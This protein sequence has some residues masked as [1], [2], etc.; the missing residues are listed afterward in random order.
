MNVLEIGG[1][2]AAAGGVAL[3]AYIAAR[4]AVLTIVILVAVWASTIAIRD[5]VD[6]SVTV[7]IGGSDF[8]VFLADVLYSTV[9]VIGVARLLTLPPAADVSSR[10]AK[11]ALIT[12]VTLFALHLVR[13][14][15]EVGTQDAIDGSRDW[16]YFIA[17]LS[18][19]ATARSE[20]G[21]N[22]WKPFVLASLALS[23]IAAL[24]FLSEGLATASEFVSDDGQLLSR[25]AVIA[26][27]TLV[28]LEGAILA[29]AFRWPSRTSAFALAGLAGTVIVLLQ[30]R[31]VWIVAVV[32]GI[33][34]LAIWVRVQL[35][36]RRTAVVALAGIAL[37]VAIPLATL[38]LANTASV[39]Q[40]VEEA[41]GEQTTLTW[42]IDGWR[43]LLRRN[44]GA[45]DIIV[46]NASGS[47]WAR[48]YMRGP[49]G[50]LYPNEVSPHNEILDSYLRLG[51]FGVVG[52]CG[53]VGAILVRRSAVGAAV[54]LPE[55]SVVLLLLAIGV[56]SLTWS[57]DSMQGLIIGALA[58][59][60]VRGRAHGAGV[61]D[62][63]PPARTVSQTT[64]VSALLASHNRRESTLACLQSF[65]G[66]DIDEEISLNA[67][68]LDDGSRDGTAGAVTE[69]FGS[70]QVLSGSGDLFWAGGMAE[71]ERAAMGL[72]PDYLLWL[73]DDV[74]LD[75]DALSRLLTT[76]ALAEGGI[77]AGAL[78]DPAGRGIT[79]SGMRRVGRHPMRMEPVDPGDV[80]IEVD[81]FNGN[82]VLVPY[83]AARTIGPL[84]GALGHAAAD[85]DYGLRAKKAGLRNLLAPGTVGACALNTKSAPWLDGHMSFMERLRSWLGPKGFPPGSRARY[86][87]RHGGL[88]WPLYW[89]A[90]YVRTAPEVL[91]GA[92]PGKAVE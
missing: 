41:T 53:L 82:V 85:F 27:G 81:T 8:H 80:P 11:W 15:V 44:H 71:A 92:A 77:A 84:D 55:W 43:K 68:L 69:S 75:A 25:R 90:P 49:Q 6:L 60:A 1:Y 3:F 37:V 31:T 65:F 46:G 19:G 33:F 30:H 56:Y 38:A 51:V 67:I 91:R 48:R 42:R 12:L 63:A 35:R 40:S 76:A 21:T 52:L 66:Q 13:G 28:I 32:A 87:S 2:L 62:V 34:G 79:Y 54:G 61:A 58:S 83:Q 64:T 10:I 70:V 18:Y 29:L 4:H 57:L 9:L 59:G 47:D 24:Y 78:R 20:L 23:L 73:N 7:G 22:L 89:I 86:L 50:G 72:R 74:I 14:V 88:I 17:G 26:S 39:R 16:L 45:S 36:H 5:T